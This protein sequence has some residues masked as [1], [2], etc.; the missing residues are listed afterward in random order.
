MLWISCQVLY[1]QGKLM[2][3]EAMCRK[4]LAL[5]IQALGEEHPD[6]AQTSWNLALLLKKQGQPQEAKLLWE[7]SLRIYQRVFGPDH[8]KCKDVEEQLAALQPVE[9]SG[10]CVVG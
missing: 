2:E 1:Q 10:G 8:Q 3:A 4:A 7:R 5:R 6:V 9:Q